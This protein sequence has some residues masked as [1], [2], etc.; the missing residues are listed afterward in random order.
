MNKTV[1]V[2]IIYNINEYKPE[3]FYL[4]PNKKITKVKLKKLIGS[5]KV[6]MQETVHCI[7][8]N[9]YTSEITFLA[10]GPWVHRAW[11]ILLN[12]KY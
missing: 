4:L 8:K 11:R 3:F 12:I 5:P 2:R 9:A 6:L 10:L 1:Y 7:T